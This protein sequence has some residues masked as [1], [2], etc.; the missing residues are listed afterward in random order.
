M[1]WLQE[2]QK[3]ERKRQRNRKFKRAAELVLSIIGLTA[4]FWIYAVI[5][6]SFGGPN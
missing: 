3:Q 5:F 4:L 2:F 6:L 1:D